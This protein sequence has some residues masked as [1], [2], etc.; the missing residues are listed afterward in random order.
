MKNKDIL[1]KENIED[2]C[3][4]NLKEIG[5]A[6][7]YIYGSDN[8]EIEIPDNYLANFYFRVHIGKGLEQ[9]YFQRGNYKVVRIFNDHIIG[10]ITKDELQKFIDILNSRSELLPYYKENNYTYWQTAIEEYNGEFGGSDCEEILKRWKKI[11]SDTLMPDYMS[12]LK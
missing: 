11:P 5:I 8:M 9:E 2:R 7:V 12:L 6:A 3:D 4:P 10:D 1:E